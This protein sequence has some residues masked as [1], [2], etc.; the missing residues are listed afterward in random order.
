MRR[1]FGGTILCLALAASLPGCAAFLDRMRQHTYPPSFD[2]ISDEQI[3]SVMWQ[4]ARDSKQIDKLVHVPGGPSADQRAEIERLLGVMLEASKKLGDERTNHALID[5]HRDA[6]QA[7]LEA[8]R[9]GV[10]SE[11][12]NYTLTE[13]IAGACVRCHEHGT[14]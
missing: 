8:A 4:L 5:E 13:N 3:D 7:D 2:Y 10:Q 11:P 1:V 12:P 6:F 9:R 14:R